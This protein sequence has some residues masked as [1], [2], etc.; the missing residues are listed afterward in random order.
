MTLETGRKL[1]AATLQTLIESL[2]QLLTI[3]HSWFEAKQQG[4][5]SRN[6]ILSHMMVVVH[7]ALDSSYAVTTDDKMGEHKLMYCLIVTCYGGGVYLAYQR[8]TSSN[9]PYSTIVMWP[10][11]CTSNCALLSTLRA[12]LFQRRPQNL[13]IHQLSMMTLIP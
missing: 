2:D 10:F 7:S 11:D 4:L 8:C 13:T 1:P 12:C 6:V 5:L 9:F 3:Y